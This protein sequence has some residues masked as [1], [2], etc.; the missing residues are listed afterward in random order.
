MTVTV[1]DATMKYNQSNWI[2]KQ[3]YH[4]SQHRCD[5]WIQDILE[6]RDSESPCQTLLDEAYVQRCLRE[7]GYEIRCDGLNI[8]PRS[9]R[10]LRELVYENC[11][12]NNKR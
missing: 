10:D 12:I 4:N 7:Q 2:A 8:F 5:A 9:S 11:N 3:S 1:D 6:D